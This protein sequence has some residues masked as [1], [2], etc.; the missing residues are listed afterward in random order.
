[1]LCSRNHRRDLESGEGLLD[2]QGFVEKLAR[3]HNDRQ[4][5][6]A[7]VQN[8]NGDERSI[9]ELINRSFSLERMN[10][11]MSK[12]RREMLWDLSRHKKFYS[13]MDEINRFAEQPRERPTDTAERLGYLENDYAEI[14]RSLEFCDQPVD[15]K[16][17]ET[18]GRKLEELLGKYLP[19]RNRDE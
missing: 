14:V 6:I 2:P 1:M 10:E 18:G 16:D 17:L 13:F 11:H 19:T 12:Q 9:L 5:L 15:R 8:G 7:S 3:L 4:R